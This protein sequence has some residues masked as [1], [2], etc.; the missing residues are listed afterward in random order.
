MAAKSSELV[1]RLKAIATL[2]TSVITELEEGTPAAPDLSAKV[3][4]RICVQCGRNVPESEQYRRG[5][6]VADYDNSRRKIMAGLVTDQELVQAGLFAPR[7]IG[8]RSQNRTPL[9][10]YL[11]TRH[12]RSDADAEAIA[13][14]FIAKK[15]ELAA[16]KKPSPKPATKPAE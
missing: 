9:D 15:K 10:E 16:K 12:Q 14:K 7:G 1:D 4:A 11:A 6:C 5:C 13:Q 3:A 2:I 8:T